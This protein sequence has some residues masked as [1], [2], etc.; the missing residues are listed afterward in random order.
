MGEDHSSASKS[1][2]LRFILVPAVITLAI[3]ILR[4]VGEL[5]HWPAPLFNSGAG[6]GAAIIGISWLPIIFGPWFA[7][8][9]ASRGER[10]ASAG[11]CIGFSLLGL[12]V[13]VFGGFLASRGGFHFSIVGLLGF[14][15]M[16]A[17]AFVPWRAWPSLTKTLIAYAYA[18]RIPVLIVMYFALQ[19]QWGTHYDAVP[20]GYP[21]GVPFGQ[22]FLG[23]AV[24]PQLFLWIGFTVVVG[25]ICGAIAIAVARRG[26]PVPETAAS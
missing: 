1:S 26:K 22:K 8:K 13:L 5:Q 6:G 2:T 23:L 21:A 15:L 20:P 17:A 19:G 3:T 18:A 16:L 10:P 11:K 7:L 25:S 24:L 14:I 9:L 4:L 12:V